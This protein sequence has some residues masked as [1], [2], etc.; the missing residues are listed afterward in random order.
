MAYRINVRKEVA[1]FALLMEAKLRQHDKDRGKKGW[2]HMPPTHRN[3]NEAGLAQ[4]AKLY[5]VVSEWPTCSVD[6]V[7]DK[8]ADV[9]NLAMMVADQAGALPHLPK[10]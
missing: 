2:K 7:A 10:E 3:L 9:A 5:V 6:M 1:Q 8:T 4:A